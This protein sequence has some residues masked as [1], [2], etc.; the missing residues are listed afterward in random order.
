M[1]DTKRFT[2][3]YEHDCRNTVSKMNVSEGAVYALASIAD[4]IEDVVD[5]LEHI[6]ANL[7]GHAG[8]L[9]GTIASL[10]NEEKGSDHE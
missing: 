6:D 2:H 7:T 9:C 3:P 8:M 10:N 4:A 1:L 5:R